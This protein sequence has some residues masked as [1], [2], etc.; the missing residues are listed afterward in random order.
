[1]IKLVVFDFDGTLA[2]TH[3]LILKTNQEAMRVMNYPIASE[4][5][6]TS[7]IGV[8]LEAGIQML[9]PDITPEQI[10]AWVKTYR[11]VFD[12]LKGQYIPQLFPHV[13]ETLIHLY[14]TGHVL[15]VASSRHSS[16]LNA[17]LEEMGLAPYFSCILGADNVTRAKPNPDPVLITLEKLGYAASETVVVGDMPVD[18]QMGLSAGAKAVGVTYGNA[19]KKALEA[20][21]AHAVIDDFTALEGVLSKL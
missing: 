21:G 1:M 13:K 18:I 6:I 5:A 20:A 19:D 17:F 14:E 4:E 11:E 10:P 16:S 12:S 15:T 8:P 9:V 2:D 3:E 7:T